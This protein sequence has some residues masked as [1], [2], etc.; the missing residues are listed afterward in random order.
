MASGIDVACVWL[1]SF[2]RALLP[3]RPRTGTFT[4]V[5]CSAVSLLVRARPSVRVHE[6]ARRSPRLACEC[7]GMPVLP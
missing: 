6:N 5:A 7:Q 2:D 4:R 1:P 3:S